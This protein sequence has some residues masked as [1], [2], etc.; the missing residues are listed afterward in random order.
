MVVCHYPDEKHLNDLLDDLLD[1]YMDEKY[2]KDLLDHYKETV[3]L[4]SDVMKPER[5]RMVCRAF[6]RCAGIP[7]TEERIKTVPRLDEP[8]DVLF[9][10]ARFEIL[11]DLDEGRRIHG[12]WKEKVQRVKKAIRDK[13]GIDTVLL[14]ISSPKFIRLAELIPLITVAL[15]DKFKRYGTGVCGTLDALVYINRLETIFVPT[16]P[17]VFEEQLDTES[18]NIQGWRS[19]SVL[20][21][22]SRTEYLDF[23]NWP[24]RH[25]VVLTDTSTAP[26]FIRERVRKILNECPDQEGLFEP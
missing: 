24:S 23:Q 25:A 3:R 19:V 22:A 18:L 10:S 15:K 11:M 5:E 2:L 6:L 17:G 7:F 14:D 26:N 8:P 16:S 21:S 1:Y 12:E 4:L 20:M 13:E 9:D